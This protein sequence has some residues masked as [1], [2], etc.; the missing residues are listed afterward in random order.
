MVHGLSLPVLAGARLAAVVVE[1]MG[2]V[3][4]RDLD[5]ALYR[6]S[7]S[8]AMC[9]TKQARR[10]RPDGEAGMRATGRQTLAVTLQ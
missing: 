8:G 5:P 2:E 3:E 9:Q 6:A 1:D 4:P 10:S 7:R